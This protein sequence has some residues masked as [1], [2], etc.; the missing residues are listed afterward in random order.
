[1]SSGRN[2]A[3]TGLSIYSARVQPL[4]G[5]YLFSCTPILPILCQ[6]HA[7]LPIDATL[8]IS[9][10]EYRIFRKKTKLIMKLSI[11]FGRWVSDIPSIYEYISWYS[12]VTGSF[13]PA[14][15]LDALHFLFMFS[16]VC[17]V[18]EIK[19]E[20][21]LSHHGF[22]TIVYH[23]SFNLLKFVIWHRNPENN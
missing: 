3:N 7:L 16:L 12:P 14:R 1:M 6:L 13:R 11:V 22:E 23:S 5:I 21:S 18:V 9:S 17:L 8:T 20:K 19:S 2:E 15:A 4:L 10:S